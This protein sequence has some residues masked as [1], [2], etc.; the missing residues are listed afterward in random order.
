VETEYF[1]PFRNV[2][3]EGGV[4]R[5]QL[6]GC[7]HFFGEV[8]GLGLRK[9]AACPIEVNLL[10]KSLQARQDNVKKRPYFAV[11]A[12][13]SLVLPL[14]FWGYTIFSTGGKE[15]QID[16]FKKQIETLRS[17]QQ[18]VVDEQNRL[19]AVQTKV[20]QLVGVVYPRHMWNE[21]MEALN[22]NLASYTNDIVV[23][24]IEPVP[25]TGPCAMKVPPATEGKRLPNA[26][27]SATAGSVAAIRLTGTI[28]MDQEN[29]DPSIV[30][31]TFDGW[32]ASLKGMS[33]FNGTDIKEVKS[34]D[35]H[36]NHR[37][38]VFTLEMPLT[39]LIPY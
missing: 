20:N 13:A 27:S 2:E 15:A 36:P 39:A 34:I 38:N 22:Q 10:P 35:A 6:S 32:L 16:E 12:V 28:K 31:A 29:Y 33:Q 14:C 25:G 24:N 18:Q 3:I 23:L 5:E 37:D 1:N 4:S 21:L 17:Y 11:A 7:A 8:V 26:P 19:T 9:I 30:Q